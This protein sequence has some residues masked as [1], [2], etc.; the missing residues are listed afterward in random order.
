M[1]RADRLKAPLVFILGEYEL[2]RGEV[3]VR[4]MATSSQESVPLSGA[5]EFVKSN[6]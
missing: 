4:R 5:V 3:S 2:A 1:K 6:K